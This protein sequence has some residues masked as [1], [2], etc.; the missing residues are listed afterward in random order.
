[1]SDTTKKKNFFCFQ[2]IGH[3]VPVGYTKSQYNKL[4]REWNNKLQESGHEDIEVFSTS[5]AGLSSQ[6]LRG[7]KPSKAYESHKD[8]SEALDFARTYQNLYM[9]TSSA[10]WLYGK[11][12]ATS[13]FLLECYINQVEFRDIATLRRT[14]DKEAFLSEYPDVQ[15]PNYFNIKSLF[16][17]HYWAYQATRRVLNNC[18]LWHVTSPLGEISIKGLEFYGFLGLDLKGT[19]DKYNAELSK[20]GLPAIRL[21]CAETLY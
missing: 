12:H 9:H 18:W 13:L 17:S 15:I 21:R 4:L 1:M 16:T 14:G 3:I 5:V 11:K 7:S 10:R 8:P 20:L 2:G 19:H 6:F